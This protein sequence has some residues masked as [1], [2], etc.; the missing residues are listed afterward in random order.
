MT[1]Y[2]SLSGIGYSEFFGEYSWGKIDLG[3]R[4]NPIQ[5]NSYTDNGLIGLSTSFVV[6]RLSPL[7]YLD[8]TP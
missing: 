8:Y 7:K 1:D 4:V 5:L 6:T 2:N 3:T